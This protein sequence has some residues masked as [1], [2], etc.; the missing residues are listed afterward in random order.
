[1][2]YYIS[3]KSVKLP[4]GIHRVYC[5]DSVFLLKFGIK[6]YFQVSVISDTYHDIATRKKLTIEHLEYAS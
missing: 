5:V 6:N 4:K 2:S 3:A 1:M